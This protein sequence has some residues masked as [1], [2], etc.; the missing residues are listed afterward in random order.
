[1]KLKLCNKCKLHHKAKACPVLTGKLA[2]VWQRWAKPFS[3]GNWADG[4]NKRKPA[5]NSQPSL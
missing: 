2:V 4:I 5:V 1:M 3:L